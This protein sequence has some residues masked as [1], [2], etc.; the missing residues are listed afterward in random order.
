MVYF[1]LTKKLCSNRKLFQC[2]SVVLITTVFWVILFGSSI[3]KYRYR[4]YEPFRS[5]LNG[6]GVS[7]GAEYVQISKNGSDMFVK[8]KKEF[9]RY[10]RSLWKLSA[11]THV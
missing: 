7:C 5:D 10:K 9:E 8:D 1:R 2:I 6:K 4:Y 3:V 11:G